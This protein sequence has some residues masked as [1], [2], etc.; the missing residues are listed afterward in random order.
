MG[1]KTLCQGINM[2]VKTLCQGTKTWCPDT[3]SSPPDMCPDIV[4]RHHDMHPDTKNA[5]TSRPRYD[6]DTCP[7]HEILFFNINFTKL[8]FIWHRPHQQQTP[9]TLPNKPIHFVSFSCT[10]SENGSTSRPRY[11]PET[12]PNQ[13]ILFS[14]INFTKL[15][16]IW[17]RPHQQL[18]PITL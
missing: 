16:F 11:D 9:I 18:T 15:A 7:N 4:S 8:A 17:H 1:V 6:P 13:G 3:M 5:S 14:N 12:S 10:T 2:G